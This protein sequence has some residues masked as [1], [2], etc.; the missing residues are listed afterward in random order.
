MNL[1]ERCHWCGEAHA[2]GPEYCKPAVPWTP[3]QS[4]IWFDFETELSAPGAK[5]PRP[6]ILTTYDPRPNAPALVAGARLWLTHELAG[7]LEALLDTVLASPLP[8]QFSPDGTT[9]VEAQPGAL[10]LGGHNIATFDC[11]I[12]AAHFPWLRPKLWLAFEQG[13][14]LDTMVAE[15]TIQIQRGMPGELSQAALCRKYGVPFQDKDDPT[16]QAIRLSFGQ[17]IGAREIPDA[18]AA[19]ALGDPTAL[20]AVFD[21]QFSTGLVDLWD[22]A[23]LGRQQFALA[24]VG[25][26]GFRT[27]PEHVVKLQA[28]VTERV[29]MLEG[30]A[31]ECGFLRTSAKGEVSRNMKAIH[32]AIAR[33]YCPEG[34]DGLDAWRQEAHAAW[35][36]DRQKGPARN[37]ALPKEW[38]LK[39]EKWYAEEIIWREDE[40]WQTGLRT[41]TEG[42]RGCPDP[43]ADPRIPKTEAGN[44]RADRLTLEDATDQ[45]LQALA[46]WG[47]LLSIRNKDLPI[48]L[49]GAVEPV[50]SRFTILDTTRSGSSDPNQQNFGKLAGVRECIEARPG[51]ALGSSDYK[52]LEL[53]ALAQLIVERLGLTTMAGKLNAG[54]DMHA[55]LGADLMGVTYEELQLLRKSEDAAIKEAADEARDA[56]KPYNFGAN[57]GMRNPETFMLY[58][59]KSYG[60]DLVKRL[61]GEPVPAWNARRLERAKQIMAAGEARNVDQQAWIAAVKRTKNEIG[62][63]D[64]AHPRMHGLWRHNLR[65]T[66][67]ANNPFQI[68]GMRVAIR[69]LWYVLKAQLVTGEM[70]GSHV[71]AF[72]H[73]D[74]TSEMP[75]HLVQAHIKVQEALMAQ[76]S[77]DV[78]PAVFT[79]VD[80]KVTSHMSK[81]AKASKTADGHFTVT[82]V[83]MPNHLGKHA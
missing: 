1:S 39:A 59:R 82:D 2:G 50:H 81:H 34:W 44:V 69:G 19:Y 70:A 77:R 26:R 24:L 83:Q 10:Y 30:I 57:G 41:R 27:D 62:L 25:A 72:I 55:E 4:V 49:R 60:Q 76:A 45:R 38:Q 53:V 6:A 48:F 35:L 13:R 66:E 68:L 56:G 65:L 61:P 74:I 75:L 8:A 63:F 23:E 51:Y 54:I 73:D 37:R 15:R 7:V 29:A 32:E 80:S 78:C 14:F 31:R 36:A 3:A 67:A 17:F 9:Y 71:V 58:A 11:P 21:R 12:I 64:M 22:V 16:V 52:M 33:D 46:E 47:Q 5:I 18:H 28:M 43:W 42:P 79:G 20:P 40:D